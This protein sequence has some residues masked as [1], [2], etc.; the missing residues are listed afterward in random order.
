MS[1]SG[2]TLFAIKLTDLRSAKRE[3]SERLL[4]AP[5]A[6]AF[7]S[8]AAAS[9]VAPDQNVV[10]VGIGEQIVDDKPTGI[11]AV[12]FFVRVKYPEHELSKKT[13]LPKS[14][15]G[16]PVDVEETGLFRRFT[17]AMPNPKTKIRPAQPG[18]SVG[19]QDPSNQIVMA[20]T[21]GAVVKD[22]AGQYILSNN[23][24]LADESRLPAGAPIF[25]PGLLDGGNANTDQI[26][27]LTRFIALQAAGNKV[28]CAIAKV[29][30]N[31]LVSKD[32]LHIGASTG[33]D[34]A[35]I[36][37]AV[38]KFGRTTSYTVGQVKSIDTDV[39]V[40]YETGNFTFQEQIIIVGSAGLPFSAAGDSGS[41]I[42]QRGTNKAVGLLF[43]GS[44]THTIANHIGDVLQALKVTLA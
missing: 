43:A 38:H 32:V 29:T 17:P 21:F 41:L 34:D 15:D 25:Q 7:R 44:N 12:K 42:L 40:G 4:H 16:L 28:D 31:N 10:G 36:D 6:E 20:G 30:A 24:V 19:Y 13:L 37:M 8:F 26:A 2:V 11:M 3:W 14:I 9:S 35:A 18:C 23:H 27:A 22:N 33:T 39:T 1:T 5:R